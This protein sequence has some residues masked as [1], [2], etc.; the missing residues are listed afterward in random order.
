MK[1]P[2]SLLPVALLLLLCGADRAEAGGWTQPVGGYYAK[3]EGVS[4][5]ADRIFGADGGSAPYSIGGGPGR[6]AAGG[7]R[8][9]LEYGLGPGF[10]GLVA[11]EWKSAR[12]SE[13]AA[14]YTTHGFGD[15]KLG[16]RLGV[17]QRSAWPLAL[18]LEMTVPTGYDAAD[19]PSLG[20]G[21]SE[22]L[23]TAQ[24]GHGFRGGYLA[25]DL[26]G[27][28][29]PK[30]SALLVAYG[31]E[32]GLQAPAGTQLR[33]GLR[34][35]RAIKPK[36]QSVVDPAVIERNRVALS[37]AFVLRLGARLDLEAGAAGALSGANTLRGVEYT[38]GLA[39]HR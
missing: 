25:A 3:L 28:R 31:A 15:L 17:A 37:G 35:R 33:L 7:A 12:I 36:T 19:V 14:R 1:P 5:R 27:G 2:R 39:A 30:D 13:T 32:L 38:L 10:T 22:L 20:S 8:A 11:L 4:R 16:A 21:Q 24:V 34:G 23:A 26:G 9:Y 29:R 6:Y 18:Q